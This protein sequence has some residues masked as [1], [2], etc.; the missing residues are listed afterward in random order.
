[1][2][3]AYDGVGQATFDASLSALR[4]RGS[5]VLYGASSGPVP[6]V[7]PQRLNRAG[8]LFLTRPTLKDYVATR[9]ELLW[10]AGEIL[11][12]VRDGSLH[13][14]VGGRYPLESAAD[15][16]RDLEGRRTIGKLLIVP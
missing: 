12:A 15:A 1:V 16:Y 11:D 14:N 13:V 3:V 9:A 7:D 5:L 8:S 10:R 6:P 4:R 2:H